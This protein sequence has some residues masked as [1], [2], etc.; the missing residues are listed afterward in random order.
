MKNK[1]NLIKH[2]RGTKQPLYKHVYR[3]WSFILALGLVLSFQI[4]AYL[5]GRYLNIELLICTGILAAISMWCGVS[6]FRSTTKLAATAYE[7]GLEVPKIKGVRS[8][9]LQTP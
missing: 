8:C 7:N 1:G 9:I 5:K 6:I 4:P 3:L 2:Y